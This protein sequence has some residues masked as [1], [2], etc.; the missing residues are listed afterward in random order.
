MSRLKKLE[1]RW[2]RTV[3][4][5]TVVGQLAQAGGRTYFEY[6]PEFLRQ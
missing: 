4:Q 5:A 6:A 1:V 3:D 2:T